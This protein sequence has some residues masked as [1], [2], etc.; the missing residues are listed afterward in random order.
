MFCDSKSTASTLHSKLK[1]GFRD[2]KFINQQEFEAAEIE[3]PDE[4]DRFSGDVILTVTVKETSLDAL[5]GPKAI[6]DM[7]KTAAAKF[8]KILSFKLLYHNGG[9]GWTPTAARYQ[10]EY[11]SAKDACDATLNTNTA[12]GTCPP[13]AQAEVSHFQ[14][15]VAEF[16]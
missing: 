12:S 2:T 11:D 9:R 8:G 5:L 3:I 6:T 16:Y 4:I 13:H 1:H 14:M 7:A 10:V 15:F